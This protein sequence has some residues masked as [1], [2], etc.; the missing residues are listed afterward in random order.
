[1]DLVRDL[2]DKAVL[3]RN[4]RDMGRV[5]RIVLSHREGEP[6]RVVA[7]EIGAAAAASRLGPIFGRWTAALEHAFGVDEGQPL[8]VQMGDV[9]GIHDHVKVDVAFGE[10]S[11][12]T[13]E[14]RLRRW[15][16][17]IPGSS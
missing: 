10:T 3:D 7:F 16:G 6:P 11:A 8:R 15:V 17:F 4:G 2:L 13:V 5:D 14:Q 12:A 1:M 9:L